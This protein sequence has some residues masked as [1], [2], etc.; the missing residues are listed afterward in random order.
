MNQMKA[1]N[2]QTIIIVRITLVKN[3]LNRPIVYLWLRCN[4]MDDQTGGLSNYLP[5]NLLFVRQAA[6]TA[7]CLGPSADVGRALVRVL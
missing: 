3:N 5:T 2:Y 4:K 6:T 1:A 7:E